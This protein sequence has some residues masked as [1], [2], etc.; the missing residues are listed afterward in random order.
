MHACM[1][2]SV[3]MCMQCVC[4]CWCVC[5]WVNREVF[6]KYLSDPSDLFVY[7]APPNVTILSKVSQV[8]STCVYFIAA[9][10][11]YTNNL[12]RLVQ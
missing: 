8:W 4:V 11:V 1:Y 7:F 10:G 9:K 12:K 5:L 3:H 2:A 6:K